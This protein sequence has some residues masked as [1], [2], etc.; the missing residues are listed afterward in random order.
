LN[1]ITV[2]DKQKKRWKVYLRVY[3]IKL[4][5]RHPVLFYMDQ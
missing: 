2:D 5:I 3:S 4:D 1:S